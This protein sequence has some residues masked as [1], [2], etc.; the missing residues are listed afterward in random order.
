MTK[1]ERF[2]AEAKE[3]SKGRKEMS[4]ITKDAAQEPLRHMRETAAE[5]YEP[6]QDRTCSATSALEQCVRERPVVS[7]VIAAGVGVLVGRFCMH[8]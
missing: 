4:G 5:C 1:S 2:R 3:V 7:V 6:R 8:R